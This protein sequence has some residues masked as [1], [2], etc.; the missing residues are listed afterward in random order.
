MDGASFLPTSIT[1]L[2]LVG[3]SLRHEASSLSIAVRREQSRRPLRVA[4]IF[5]FSPLRIRHSHTGTSLR[6][7]LAILENRLPLIQ[8]ILTAEG[9]PRLLLGVESLRRSHGYQLESL[10]HRFSTRLLTQ[11]SGS[12]R[13]GAVHSSLGSLASAALGLSSFSAVSR[14]NSLLRVHH[15]GLPARLVSSV[16]KASSALNLSTHRPVNPL[17]ALSG[18][19]THLPL[20]ALYEQ[21][22]S[23][24]TLDGSRGRLR[25][26]ARSVTPPVEARSISIL[27]SAR[28]RR[29]H[30]AENAH[31]SQTAQ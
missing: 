4:S 17:P 1:S 24:L 7:L 27:T 9:L 5:S 30:A 31:S 11:T 19:V 13:F 26:V 12:D 25:T 3:A 29:H 20:S 2:I 18:S 28:H 21:T 14:T 22:A 15:T 10:V 6:P 8:S 16:A 23:V